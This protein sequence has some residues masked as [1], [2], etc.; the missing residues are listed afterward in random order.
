LAKV[1]T[2][3][4]SETTLWTW[5]AEHARSMQETQENREFL[6]GVNLPR[7]LKFSS[8]L[9]GAVAGAAFIFVVVPSHAVR[10]ILDGAKGSLPQDTQL[11]CASKGIEEG[12]LHLM[13]DV[14]ESVV[15]PQNGGVSR[16]A[17][18][19]GPSFAKEVALKVPTNLVAASSSEEL[20]LNLQHL[21]SNDW[22]RVYTSPDPIGVEVGGALKNVVAIAAGACDGLGFGKN[23]QAALMTRGI[24]EMGRLAMALGGDARTVSGLAG[25]GDLILTCTGEMSRNRTLGYKLGQGAELSLALST[26]DGVAEGYLTAKSAHLLSQ[27]IGVDLPICRAVYSVLH[28]GIGIQGALR[29]LLSRPLGTE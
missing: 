20:A 2:E 12:T 7:V 10:S 21:L 3:G 18:L 17:V 27:R 16:V 4:G 23:T 22:L 28:E 13:T 8:D 24:A 11:V 9:E 5:Q 15:A 26:S 6:P 25:V 19:S 14:M 29:T 1:L